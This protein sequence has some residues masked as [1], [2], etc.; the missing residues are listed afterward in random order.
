M[1]YSTLSSTAALALA[2]PTA[3]GD[4]SIYAASIGGNGISGN[5]IGWQVYPRTIL[6]IGCDDALGWI[7]RKSNDVSGGKYGV[8]CKGS[9][10]SCTRSGSGEG[11]KVLELNARQTS[12]DKDP[13]FSEY[14]SKSRYHS[15]LHLFIRFEALTVIISVLCQPRRSHRRSQRQQHRHVF[16]CARAEFLLWHQCRTSARNTQAGLHLQP[17]RER[18]QAALMIRSSTFRRRWDEGVSP[19]A[20]W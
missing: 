2:I 10:D 16:R 6:A 12:K 5:S 14:Y 18:L 1:K 17:H 11:I 15:L 19:V 8:R 9:K 4:F 20:R 13:H 7:W 3:F